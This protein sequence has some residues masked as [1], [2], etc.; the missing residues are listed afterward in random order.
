MHLFFFSAISEYIARLF[1]SIRFTVDE[2]GDLM[3]GWIALNR[4]NLQ[5]VG[6]VELWSM[7]R[8]RL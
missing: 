2:R 3:V 8:S 7:V 1:G 5:A 6:Y 4:G